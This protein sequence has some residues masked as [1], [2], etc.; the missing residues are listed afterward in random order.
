MVESSR[1]FFASCSRLS[2]SAISFWRSSCVDL[3]SI[4]ESQGS[5][6]PVHMCGCLFVWGLSFQLKDVESFDDD[7][8]R[9]FG[10]KKKSR[11]SASQFFNFAKTELTRVPL[12]GIILIFLLHNE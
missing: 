4:E 3:V 2:R 11:T 5:S 7:A 10:G 6:S 9:Q 8:V 12:K 1:R